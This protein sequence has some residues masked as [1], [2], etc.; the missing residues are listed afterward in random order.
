VELQRRT[1]DVGTCVVI[2]GADSRWETLTVA[3]GSFSLELPSG[4]YTV[5]AARKR[6]LPASKEIIHSD[7]GLT[8]ST[9]VLQVRGA[10]GKR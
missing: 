5:R 10:S 3:D 7:E 6:F 4:S 8:L 1:G 2:E 9:V